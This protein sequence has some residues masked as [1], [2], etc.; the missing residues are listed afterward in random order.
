MVCTFGTTFKSTFYSTEI[1]CLCLGNAPKFTKYMF[2]QTGHPML[3]GWLR[4]KK[5]QPI[6]L[7]DY[8]FGM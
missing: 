7:L 8:D 1:I 5:V 3:E 6:L 4:G 2:G